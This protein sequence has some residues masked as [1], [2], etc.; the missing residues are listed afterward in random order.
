ML[1]VACIMRKCFALVLLFVTS[2]SV[3][4]QRSK[5]AGSIVVKEELF[6][7]LEKAVGGDVADLRRILANVKAIPKT[8][9]GRAPLLQMASLS[10]AKLTLLLIAGADPNEMVPWEGQGLT[11]PAFYLVCESDVVNGSLANRGPSSAETV[12]IMRLVFLAGANPNLV[13]Y[14]SGKARKV[15][16]LRC[17]RG[18][19]AL[20]PA[21]RQREWERLLSIVPEG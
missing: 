8:P 3:S 17:D 14:S 15:R 6:T 19:E 16:E 10:E 5:E 9:P 11:V 21:V 7:R 4:F 18:S 13:Y 12:R 1:V 20:H 2:I